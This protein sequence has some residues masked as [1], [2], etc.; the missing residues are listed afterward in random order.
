V[1][2]AAV[3]VVF[4]VPD[5]DEAQPDEIKAQIEDVQVV[6]TIQIDIKSQESSSTNCNQGVRVATATREFEITAWPKASRGRGRDLPRRRRPRQPGH[7]R[8][9]HCT[10]TVIY[11]P[12]PG[13]RR[14]QSRCQ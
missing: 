9:N 14:S 11:L 7:C 10:V 3:C 12:A 8:V 6:N 13:L 5:E 1:G 4:E 2:P